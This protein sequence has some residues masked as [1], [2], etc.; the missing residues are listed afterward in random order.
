MNYRHSYHAGN[1]ADVFKHTILVALIE[2]L[3]NKPKPFCYLD[4]H[5]GCGQYDLQSAEALKTHEY[6]S[7][8]AKILKAN[9]PPEMI[10]KYLA[11]CA[12]KGSHFYPGS[13]EI[14]RSLL[15]LEDRMILSELH[16]TDFQTLKNHFYKDRQVA[17]HQQ[18][19]WQSLKAFLPPKERRGLILIDPPYEQSDELLTLA[20]KIAPGLK[21]FE[22]GIFAIWYPIKRNM[23]LN[24]FHR[25][26]KETISLPML[27]VDM[28]LW[29]ED[30]AAT[31][32]GC[33][34]LIIN[35]PWQFDLTLKSFLPWLWEHLSPQQQGQLY[36]S[37]ID[38]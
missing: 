28:T 1:F 2:S 24:A 4:T 25:T 22:T 36:F 26:C 10:Q 20:E 19:A 35:P 13:P 11:I 29:P 15:R 37:N 5:A 23:P 32:N 8:I 7:G 38:F 33:G 21:R 16:P 18:D 17:V 27:R 9:N 12:D 30:G 3:K 14:T 6:K 31:L 34:M